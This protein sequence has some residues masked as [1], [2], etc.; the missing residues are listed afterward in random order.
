M[1]TDFDSVDN[2]DGQGGANPIHDE[3]RDVRCALKNE[4]SNNGET[5]TKRVT[6]QNYV[7]TVSEQN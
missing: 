3:R 5:N 7:Y 6:T 4:Y 2:C 1:V